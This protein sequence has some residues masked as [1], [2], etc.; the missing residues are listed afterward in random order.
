[1][2]SQQQM[3]D[4]LTREL[5]FRRR[6]YPGWVARGRMTQEKAEHEIMCME[7]ILKLLD[8]RQFELPLTHNPPR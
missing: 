5:A 4:C 8:P 3:I 2:I 6:C 7:N 1:M